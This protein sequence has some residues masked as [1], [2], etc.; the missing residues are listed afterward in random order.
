MEGGNVF[1]E[2]KKLKKEGPEGKRVERQR[3]ILEGEA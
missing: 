3:L 1:L 2:E